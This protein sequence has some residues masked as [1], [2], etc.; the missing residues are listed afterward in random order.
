M[1][2]MTARNCKDVVTNDILLK[3]ASFHELENLIKFERQERLLVLLQKHNA[4]RKDRFNSRGQNIIVY[5]EYHFQWKAVYG[6]KTSEK[7]K[8][9]QG[10]CTY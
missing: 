3:H 6:V 5:P 7:K 9:E 4:E 1:L 2:N 8:E 10:N